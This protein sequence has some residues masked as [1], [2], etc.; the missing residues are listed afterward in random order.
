MKFRQL[1]RSGLKVSELAFGCG[2]VLTEGGQ[3]QSL[4]RQAFDQGV[5]FFD[6]AEA[7]AQ[8][9]SEIIL[10]QAL[11]G[12]RR[13][14]L[15]ISSKL[16]GTGNGANQSGL[17]RKH[18]IEGTKMSLKRMQLE[19]VD[20][21]FCHRVD[22][23][24]PLEETVQAMDF[25]VCQ[26]HA[27]YWGTSE[28][29]VALLEETFRICKDLNCLAPSVEQPQYSLLDRSKF[30]EQYVPLCEKYGLGTSVWGALACG[31]LAGR[32][33]EGITQGSRLDKSPKLQSKLTAQAAQTVEKLNKLAQE[34][35]CSLA[36]LA[37]AW[38]LASPYVSSV[39]LGVSSAEQ[40]NECLKTSELKENLPQDFIAKVEQY[41]I[42]SN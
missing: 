28:W 4:I 23:N 31:V 16:F 3:G 17:S 5:N 33:R 42:S 21:L 18:L 38:C 7:Y 26:G 22:P 15:V 32:Y 1:G 11:K 37:I 35:S 19:Y 24:T 25:L 14:D 2:T 6:T 13:E 34:L 12:L 20:I 9:Q 29:P 8:G 40:L 41:C 39:I 36:Q 10:G 30:E 27:L